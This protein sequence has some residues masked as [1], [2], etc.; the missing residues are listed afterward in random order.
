MIFDLRIRPAH[1]FY[2]L[3]GGQPIIQRRHSEQSEE[4]RQGLSRFFG[5]TLVFLPRRLSAVQEGQAGPQN[6]DTTL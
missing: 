1:P 5:Q 2:S 6:D 4:S 3:N